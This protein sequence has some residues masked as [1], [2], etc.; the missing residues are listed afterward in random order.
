MWDLVSLQ[1]PRAS[2][3]SRESVEVGMVGTSH[4]CRTSSSQPGPGSPSRS[5]W[6]GPRIPAGPSS[7]QPGP[8]SPSRSGW[9]G[10]R[11]PAGTSSIDQVPGVRRGRDGW[12]LVSLQDLEQSARSRERGPRCLEPGC[13]EPGCLEPGCLEPGCLVIAYLHQKK[14]YF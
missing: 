4:P 7:S 14:R 12:D 10:P 3:R 1:G 9:L 13:L 6:L 5:G 8:G 11:I 2:T